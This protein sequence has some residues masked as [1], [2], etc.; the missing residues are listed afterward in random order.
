MCMKVL[1]N[2][3]V[4]DFMTKIIRHSTRNYLYLSES[5]FLSDY[6]YP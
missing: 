5:L 1:S 6:I 3:T 4:T 2:K